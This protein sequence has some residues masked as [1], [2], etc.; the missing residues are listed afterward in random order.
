M[1]ECVFLYVFVCIDSHA[2]FRASPML[3]IHS[4]GRH[5]SG[6]VD[7]VSKIEIFLLCLPGTHLFLFSMFMFLLPQTTSLHP[8]TPLTCSS[9]TFFRWRV[10][11][12]WVSILSTRGWLILPFLSA[13]YLENLVLLFSSFALCLLFPFHNLAFSLFSPLEVSGLPLS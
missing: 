6:L 9:R 10:M 13:W 1:I 4:G 11:L 12:S 2:C 8:I 7:N 3:A 5:Y